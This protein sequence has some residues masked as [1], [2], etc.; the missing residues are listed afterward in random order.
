MRLLLALVLNI[1]GMLATTIVPGIR[2]QGNW[3]T[4]VIA[5]ILFAFVNAVIRPIAIFLSIPFLIVTLG[6]FYFILNGLLLYLAAPLIPGY[7]VSGLMPA[8]VGGLV[9]MVANWILGA[10]FRETRETPRRG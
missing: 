3:V 7:T 1:F 10:I 2:F 4:L 5:G 9:L 8:I 6:L